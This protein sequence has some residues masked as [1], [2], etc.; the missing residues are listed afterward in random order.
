M[1]TWSKWVHWAN[2]NVTVK[3]MNGEEAGLLG[4][5][6]YTK[7]LKVIYHGRHETIMASD[8]AL[9]CEPGEFELAW[10]RPEVWPDEPTP[11]WAEGR[12]VAPPSLVVEVDPFAL[13]PS[14][15]PP[16]DRETEKLDV[17]SLRLPRFGMDSDVP[18]Y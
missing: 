4:A 16:A 14:F 3:L 11:D 7:K 2:T 17:S 18:T 15:L 10:V 8:V 12:R 13:H 6:R 1:T 5:Q 9:V